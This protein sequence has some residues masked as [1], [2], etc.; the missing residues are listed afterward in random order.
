MAMM[1][2]GKVGFGLD[3][4][5]LIDRRGREHWVS[6]GQSEKPLNFAIG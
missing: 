3:A 6:A 4:V 1:D 5:A 2:A